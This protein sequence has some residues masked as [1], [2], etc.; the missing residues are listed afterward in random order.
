MTPGAPLLLAA[1]I[2]ASPAPSGALPELR[3]TTSAELR[4]AVRRSGAPVT[5]VN[6]WAT[7]CLPCRE[8]LPDLVR[9]AREMAPRGVRVV[10]LSCDFA[11]DVPAAREFLARNGVT[12]LSFVKKD[13]PDQEFIDGLDPRWSGALPASFVFDAEGRVRDFWEGK[14][15]A[16]R[17]L[18]RVRAILD[19]RH[20]GPR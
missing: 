12:G 15:D 3:P 19:A 20:G 6:A 17:I 13:G 7:W 9:V 2:A 4:E 11:D 1:A 16:A 14:A 5:L 18:E 10:F 8:E